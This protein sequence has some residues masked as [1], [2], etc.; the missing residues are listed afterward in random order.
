MSE[1]RWEIL[2]SRAGEMDSEAVVS[3][4]VDGGDK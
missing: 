1:E 3:A 2:L 4:L